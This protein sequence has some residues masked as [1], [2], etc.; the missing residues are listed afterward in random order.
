M[1]RQIAA[2][3]LFALLLTGCTARQERPEAEIAPGAEPE[4]AV[5]TDWSKLTPYAP[6]Q[7]IFGYH[8]GYSGFDA[9]QPRGDYGALLPYIGKYSAMSMYVID[10]L[11]LYG[12]VSPEGELVTEPIYADVRYFDDFMLLYRG[13]PEGV[14]GGD[15]Y[16]GGRFSRTLA[17]P[18]GSWT[19]ELTD[20]YYVAS[21]ENLLM[22][23][24]ADNSLALWNAQGEVIMRFDGALFAPYLGE[25]IVWGEEGGPWVDWADERLGY[26]TSF[27]VNREYFEQGVRL[28]LDFTDGSVLAEPPE[29]YP[30][31]MV[32]EERERTALEVADAR[33]LTPY[34]D[35]FTGELYYYGYYSPDGEPPFLPAVFDSEGK[36]LL[37]NIGMTGYEAASVLRAGLCSTIEDGCF[38]YRSLKD[39]SLVFRKFMRTNS[40]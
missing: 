8:A 22:T 19:R 26:V 21:G 30:A 13:D 14:S 6:P 2:A 25:N 24:S 34:S 27:Q 38:C 29:G 35:S 4:S 28:Y 1:K 3:L 36:L 31:E 5:Y 20:S 39:K 16:A 10:S 23:A 33:N 40:D 32:Y 37:E 11:P 15:S 7:E 9:F 12:L 17:A 18:D